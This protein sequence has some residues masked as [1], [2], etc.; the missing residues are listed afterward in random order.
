MEFMPSQLQKNAELTV[1]HCNFN[2][3][4]TH[5]FRY[6]DVSAVQR[7]TADLTYQACRHR[8]DYYQREKED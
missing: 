8:A 3:V 4:P 2:I 1:L 5:R 6:A 7:T